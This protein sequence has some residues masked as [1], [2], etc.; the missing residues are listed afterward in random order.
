MLHLLTSLVY[1]QEEMSSSI[2][3]VTTYWGD[4]MEISLLLQMLVFGAIKHNLL[5]EMGA[6][7]A[8]G[9]ELNTYKMNCGAN[10]FAKTEDIF[11][12]AQTNVH[13]R[14]LPL[15]PITAAMQ[16]KRCCVCYLAILLQS[17]K[18]VM[19]TEKHICNLYTKYTS[20]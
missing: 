4:V 2:Q 15:K 14:C 19:C 11:Q 8:N 9:T 12:G 6:W 16:T 5:K 7:Q 18:S 13:Y 10:T 1:L 3:N 20:P 17:F